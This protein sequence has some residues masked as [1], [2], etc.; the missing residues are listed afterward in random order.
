[1]RAGSLIQKTAEKIRRS[2][3]TGGPPDRQT[4]KESQSPSWEKE[5]HRSALSRLTPGCEARV[6]TEVDN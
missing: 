6:L 1:M 5:C 2:K 3:K 4:M